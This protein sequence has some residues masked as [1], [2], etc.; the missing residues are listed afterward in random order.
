MTLNDIDKKMEEGGVHALC[1]K[2]GGRG[3]L[4]LKFGFQVQL[5]VLLKPRSHGVSKAKKCLLM[6]SP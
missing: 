3:V 1:L 4:S 5:I 6:D 2:K